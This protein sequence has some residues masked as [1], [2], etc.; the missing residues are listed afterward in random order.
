MRVF[1]K[2][3]KT[4]IRGVLAFTLLLTVIAALWIAIGAPWGTADRTVSLNT[5]IFT[6][7]M[8]FA[9][10]LVGYLARDAQE[11]GDE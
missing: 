8:G 4:Q 5:E 6:A 7:L 3:P 9:G 1:G 11:P 10:L 2:K